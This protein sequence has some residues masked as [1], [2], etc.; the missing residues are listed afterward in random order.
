MRRKNWARALSEF[1][2]AEQLSPG[3]PGL[4]LNISLAQFHRGTFA[5]AIQPLQLVL[6]KDP[7]SV[8]AHYLLGLC[9]FATDK[10]REAAEQLKPLWETESGKM[11][12]CT[13]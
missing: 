2:S 1:R 8:Q 4:E 11:P 5:A 7:S 13:Y 12:I 9:Y 3:N 10:Y 6:D